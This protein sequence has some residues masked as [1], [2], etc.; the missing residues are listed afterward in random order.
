MASQNNAAASD[1]DEV[2]TSE[3]D[4]DEV[5]SEAKKRWDICVD[6]ESYSRDMY[7]DDDKFGHADSDN[8]YQWPNQLLTDRLLQQRPTLTINK[9]RIHALQVINDAK[10]NKVGINVHPTTTEATYEAAQ[11]FE[12]VVRHIEYRSKAQEAYD[13]AMDRAVFPGFGYCRV[14]SDYISAD[15]FDQELL[16][17]RVADPLTIYID[18]DAKEVDKSDMDYAFVFDDMSRDRFDQKYPKFKDIIPSSALGADYSAYA[19]WVSDD[20]VRIAEYWRRKHTKKTLVSVINPETGER[21]ARYRDELDPKIIKALKANKE[22]DYRDRETEKIQVE[23]FKIAGDEIIGHY[24]WPGKH[25]PIVPMVGE[26][27]VIDGRMDRKGLIRYIKDAQR[28]YNIQTSAEV[29]FGALQ[30][31]TP[32]VGPAVAF[33]GYE[34]FYRMANV[35]NLAFLPYKHKDA[36]GDPVPA[37]TRPNPPQASEAYLEGRKIAQEEMMMASGQ[38]QAQMGENENAKSG[39]AINERQRQGDNATYHF[40]NAQAIMVRQ[41]GRILIE[42]IPHFYDTP[43]LLRIEGEDGIVKNIR[44]DP[45]APQGAQKIPSQDP[46][47]KSVDIILNPNVGQY[48]VESDVGPSYATRR[49][50]AWNAIIQILSQDKALAPVIGDLLF[51]NGDF[52]GADE[53][54]QRL[55]RLVPPAALQDGPS[56]QDQQMQGQMQQLTQVVQELNEKLKDKTAEINIKSFDAETKRLTAIGNA[57]PI[58][59]PQQAQPLIGEAVGQMVQGGPPQTFDPGMG[60]QPNGLTQPPMQM[61]QQNAM[62]PSSGPQ[63]PGGAGP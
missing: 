19:G 21:M 46:N 31:K 61:P 18:P 7:V 17:K 14:V 5:V 8:Q 34:E 45:N 38:Y 16:I 47:A 58:V 39:V 37:P 23:C 29:E 55:R 27:T 2:N 51:L 62:M 9:A 1:R 52:P 22:L 30:T 10:Q 60:P 49:Q 43:R 57:G 53:I 44:I 13:W 15:S 42:C 24:K 63:M 41:I 48:S 3:T 6:Y 12:D 33:E 26:E 4:E 36:Q 54:A 59:S 25:I 35:Q 20:H 40:V 56:P 28:I 32:W 50:E 11:V